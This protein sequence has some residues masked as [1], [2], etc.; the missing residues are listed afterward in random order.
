M[1][2]RTIK[3]V[4]RI[5][6]Q[7]FV[8]NVRVTDNHNYFVNGVLTHNCD[9]AGLIPD[10][11][12]TL[13]LRML[14][15]HKDN[16]LV[17]IGNPFERN[18][19]YTSYKSPRYAKIVVDYK[20]ALREG[21]YTREFIEEMKETDPEMFRILYEC[22]FPDEETLLEGKWRPLFTADQVREFIEKPGEGLNLEF[23]TKILGIDLAGEGYN[24]NV[25]V[26]RTRNYA[27]VLFKKRKV[28]V[29]F[30]ANY[31]LDKVEEEK[32][33]PFNVVL[34]KQGVGHGLYDILSVR[35]MQG[36]NVGTKARD[37]TTFANLRAELL[38][39]FYQWLLNGGKLSAANYD[40]W[41]QLTRIY[42][43]I[44][45]GKLLVMSKQEAQARGIRSPDVID[46]TILTFADCVAYADE[47][48]F[49]KKKVIDDEPP[50]AMSV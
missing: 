48:K 13:I 5:K 20:Q 3:N 46:A 35:G 37:S 40:D 39:R 27:R 28:K 1:E 21:R 25:G 31:I 38:Y 45:N 49:S 6:K 2:E 34:D 14:G 19:F 18:H 16:F 10:N 17:K 41:F 12:N 33:N 47:G 26:V 32:I 8:Y 30:L 50:S 29:P 42:I 22:K 36:V 15:G 11:K 9:E 4:R 44:K 23:G 7:D 43:R 24:Y